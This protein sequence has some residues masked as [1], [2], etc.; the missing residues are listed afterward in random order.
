MVKFVPFHARFDSL[1]ILN[2]FLEFY[3]HFMNFTHLTFFFF[4]LWWFTAGLLQSAL[5]TQFSDMFTTDLP[6]KNY[7]IALFRVRWI[8]RWRIITFFCFNKKN[9]LFS[10]KFSTSGFHWICTLID[11]M[12]AIWLYSE[13]VCVTNFMA[14]LIQKLMHK[15]YLNII[16]SWTLTYTSVQN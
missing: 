8:N 12:D 16:F 5:F 11:A 13:N 14:F 7:L 4:I 1:N 10:L 15:V 3:K 6:E 9:L 2:Q